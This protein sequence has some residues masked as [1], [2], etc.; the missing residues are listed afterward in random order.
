MG[1]MAFQY[2]TYEYF[3]MHLEYILEDETRKAEMGLSAKETA[4]LYSTWN[5]CT[6]AE[7]L[8]K[9]VLK[10]QEAEK[11]AT[12]WAHRAYNRIFMEQ[13]RT[14]KER[15]MKMM[16]KINMLSKA[17]MVK[18]QGVLSAHDEQVALGKAGNEAGS[19]DFGKCKSSM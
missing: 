13:K 15:G 14:V 9:E 7:R 10:R 12:V 5:F 16:K 18:G 11:E 3:K 2:E 19:P 4:Y 17:D 1:I 6:M 8:Y